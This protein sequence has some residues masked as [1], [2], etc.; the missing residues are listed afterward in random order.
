MPARRFMGRRRSFGL[1]PVIN[2][3]KNMP[4][5][6]IPLDT[7]QQSV[8]LAK[9][10]NAPSNTVSTDTAHGSVIKAIWLSLDVCGLGASGGLV[11]SLTYIMKNPGANLTPPGSFSIGTSNEKKFV[12]RTFSAMLMRNQEGNPPVHWEGWIKIP[13]R[14]QRMGTDD[15]WVLSSGLNSGT[16]HLMWQAIYKWYT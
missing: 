7:T 10:V 2:S 14:Y 16:G 6:S 1:R 8:D 11:R 9:A 15:T 3:I 13:K 4:N 12:I 5:G